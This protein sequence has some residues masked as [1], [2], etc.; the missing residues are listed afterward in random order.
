MSTAQLTRRAA[1]KLADMVEEADEAHAIVHSISRRINELEKQA[2]YNPARVSAELRADLDYQRAKLPAAQ[3]RHAHLL[4]LV[5][6]LRDWIARLRPNVEL[7]DV[8]PRSGRP[9]KDGSYAQAVDK[10]RA[11]IDKLKAEHQSVRAALPTLDEVN[12]E[13]DAWITELAA[14]GKPTLRDRTSQFP[15]NPSAL[16]LA[17]WLH[18]DAL[19]QRLRQDVDGE[20]EADRAVLSKEEKA[21]KL[22]E[23]DATILQLERD[24]E[25]LIMLALMEHEQHIL[26]RLDASPESMLGVTVARRSPA[27]PAPAMPAPAPVSTVPPRTPARVR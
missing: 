13:I 23:L 19:R 21:T 6:R 1:E 24:E 27:P 3:Q 22:A 2:G 5:T 10:L 4:Q 26:R 14:R 18:P 17:A 8:P 16:E 11:D 15:R 9:V 7:R 12:G 20:R 25:A